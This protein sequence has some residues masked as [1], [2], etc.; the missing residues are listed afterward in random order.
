MTACSDSPNRPA[1]DLLDRLIEQ[2]AWAKTCLLVAAATT[3]GSADRVRE[4]D[5]LRRA[6]VDP[7]RTI[8]SVFA[9]GQS[10][11]RDV[12]IEL[13]VCELAIPKLEAG[14]VLRQD[15]GRSP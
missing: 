2:V 15:S 5:E 8:D 13:R 1:R 14:A 4:L 11:P 6:V 9:Q 7:R 10:L 12:I 3:P